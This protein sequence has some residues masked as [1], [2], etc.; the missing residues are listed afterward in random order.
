[1]KTKH[2]KIA[3]L[4]ATLERYAETY[5]AC[6]CNEADRWEAGRFLEAAKQLRALE[7]ET[8][9][10]AEVMENMVAVLTEWH[11]DMPDCVGDKEPDILT[12][13]LAALARHRAKQE[14]GT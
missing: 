11:A 6:A 7:A 8:Q 4:A 13:A 1:M 12:A 2:S 10:L 14:V 3:G 9:E 5:N